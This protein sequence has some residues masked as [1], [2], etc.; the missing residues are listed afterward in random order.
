M[1]E[2]DARSVPALPA[3]GGAGAVG[4]CVASRAASATVGAPGPPLSTTA[5][6][7]AAAAAAPAR[8]NLGTSRRLRAGLEPSARRRT[9]TVALNDCGTSSFVRVCVAR[10]ARRWRSSSS[11]S[12]GEP[13][14]RASTSARRSAGRVP[15]ASA[16][17]SAI[18]AE[19]NSGARSLT[20]PTSHHG[21]AATSGRLTASSRSGRG[22]SGQRCRDGRGCRDC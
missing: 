8:T 14:T 12:S 18:S 3:G 11:C 22:G 5:A 20:T 13:A 4:D 6:T 10:T 21:A 16:Q 2:F 7:T 15:S 1:H 9:S 19:V 17:T